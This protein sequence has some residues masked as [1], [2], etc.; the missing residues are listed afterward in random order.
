MEKVMFEVTVLTITA[1]ETVQM[2]VIVFFVDG[3]QILTYKKKILT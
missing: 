3:I 1:A 2:S